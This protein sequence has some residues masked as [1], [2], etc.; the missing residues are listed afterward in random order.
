MTWFCLA[1]NQETVLVIQNLQVDVSV[2]DLTFTGLFLV[3]Y[4]L[5]Q[6]F[7]SITSRRIR[8]CSTSCLLQEAR[9][10]WDLQGSAG[11]WSSIIRC[12]IRAILDKSRI[13]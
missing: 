2:L 10:N 9:L 8:E 13:F 11:I 1:T 7:I 5:Y 6:M 12:W 4:V 3:L